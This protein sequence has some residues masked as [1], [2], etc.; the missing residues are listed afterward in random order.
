[1][2]LLKVLF[3]LFLKCY[4]AFLMF[5]FLKGEF[6]RNAFELGIKWI[7]YFFPSLKF[8]LQFEG[9]YKEIKFFNLVVLKISSLENN[10]LEIY[11]YLI[12]ALFSQYSKTTI[13]PLV[14]YLTY[15][16]PIP[17]KHFKVHYSKYQNSFNALHATIPLKFHLFCPF[18]VKVVSTN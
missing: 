16:Y 11:A 17:L 6:A 14:C 1:M 10:I 4:F 3:G 18:Y 9:I 13:C 7:K 8:K 5:F 12:S 2:L 15:V